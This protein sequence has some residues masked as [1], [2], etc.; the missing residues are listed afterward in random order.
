MPTSKINIA[1]HPLP[2][3]RSSIRCYNL[4]DKL[5][6]WNTRKSLITALQFKIGVAYSRNAHLN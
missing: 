1:N 5:M 3:Q 2:N 6:S 4:T